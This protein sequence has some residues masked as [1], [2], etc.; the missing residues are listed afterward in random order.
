MEEKINDKMNKME[1][2]IDDRFN[3]I[4][5]LVMT[6]NQSNIKHVSSEF[7]WKKTKISKLKS[8][9]KAA[10]TIMTKETFQRNPMTLNTRKD[11]KK[12]NI[13]LMITG[14]TMHLNK[15]KQKT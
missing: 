13:K 6:L 8:Y 10:I 5:Q 1:K 14:K 7:F 12:Q 11:L 9:H 2:K 15:Q 3:K 4:E